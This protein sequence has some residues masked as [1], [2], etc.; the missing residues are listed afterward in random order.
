MKKIILFIAFITLGFNANAQFSAG[1][2][3]GLP[4]GDTD[5]LFNFALGI[6]VNYMFESDT[7][8][9]YGIASGYSLYFGEEFSEDFFG[10]TIEGEIPNTSFLPLAAAGRYAISD[11]FSLGADMGY[12]IGLGPDGNDGG[13]YIRPMLAYNL[14]EK[15]SL[16]FSYSSVSLDGGSF[17]NLGLGVMFAL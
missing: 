8:F 10:E 7:K 12:A 4:V 2:N 13:F 1:V 11:Q 14:S 16:S 17:A 5:G 6:D 3:L 15:A 9:S